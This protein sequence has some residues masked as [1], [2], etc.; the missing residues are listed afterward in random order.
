VAFAD[1]LESSSEAAMQNTMA[2]NGKTN[3]VY[4]FH[5]LQ[6]FFILIF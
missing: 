1:I 5:P 6:T 4:E 2:E 3:G